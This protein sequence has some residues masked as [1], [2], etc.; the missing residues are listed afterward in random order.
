[1]KLTGWYDGKQ[2]PVRVGVYERDYGTLSLSFNY[3]AYWDG[4][5]WYCATARA[6]DAYQSRKVHFDWPSR[7]QKLPWR[8]VAA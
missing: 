5:R 8:G 3:Y 1:M 4:K 7:H 2:K 6:R